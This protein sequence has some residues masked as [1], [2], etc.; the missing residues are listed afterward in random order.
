MATR[1][2]KPA[3]LGQVS[4]IDLRLLRVFRAVVESGGISAAEPE[5]GIGRSTISRHLKDLEQ[6]LGVTLCNRG[7]A[8]FSL[9]AEG[10]QI[11]QSTLTLLGALDSFRAEVADS[12]R[13]PIG[14]LNFAIFEKSLGNPNAAIEVA[15]DQFSQQAERVELHIYGGTVAEIESGVIDGKYQIG[16]VPTHRLASG[17]DYAPLF[18]EQMW[19]YCG[20]R[21]PL[22]ARHGQVRAEQVYSHRYVGLG[23]HSPNFENSHRLG[24]K[25]SATAYDQEAIATLILSGHYVGFLPEHFAQPL[26]AAGLLAPLAQSEMS[27]RC[28]FAA[29]VR[30]GKQPSRLVTAMLDQLIASH[31]YLPDAK[32]GRRLARPR[33]AAVGPHG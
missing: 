9:T 13:Q 22:Y 21:H 3:Q 10:A 11:Y 5:L 8:G 26:Q 15:I 29:A 28:Q 31:R 4:D 12:Q 27:Y 24:L 2:R 20:E 23:Y 19:L 17:L 16:I 18:D 33:Q 6:R 25:R 1:S 30:G 7:R 32:A 14:R